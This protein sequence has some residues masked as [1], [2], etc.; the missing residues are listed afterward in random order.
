MIGRLEASSIF[1]VP[2]LVSASVVALGAPVA[3]KP[4][5]NSLSDNVAGPTRRWLTVI[6]CL[7]ITCGFVG[8][9]LAYETC[10]NYNVAAARE[11]ASGDQPFFAA[12]Q[13][14]AA[15]AWAPRQA[16]HR[17]PGIGTA[18]TLLT[19]LLFG[20]RV[21]RRLCLLLASALSFSVTAWV[22]WSSIY[23][24]S[25]W[26]RI[27]AGI[28]LGG[29]GLLIGVLWWLL[30][31]NRPADEYSGENFDEY[32]GAGHY[33][34]LLLVGI[35]T[36][37]LGVA[38]ASSG[39]L[40][41]G[42]LGFAL[43]SSVAGA[44]TGWWLRRGCWSPGWSGPVAVLSG[45]LMIFGCAFSELWLT[46]AFLIWLSLILVALVPP[47]WVFGKSW[48]TGMTWC[49][50]ILSPAMIATG[51]AVIRAVMAIRSEPANPYDAYL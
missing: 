35:I 12:L 17:L 16:K 31:T 7:A 32:S 4:A 25:E 40:T 46:H 39:S 13:E 30:A 22:L 24:T 50:A 20:M 9:H 48:R 11:P 44:L 34:R 28:W 26:T 19:A 23:V 42:L 49:F 2:A 51:W 27:E 37:L 6:W 36:G 33:G 43:S 41:I 38:L 14:T 1:L 3:A 29:I 47:K 15:D 21:D 5:S 18:V 10:S 45:L 8:G